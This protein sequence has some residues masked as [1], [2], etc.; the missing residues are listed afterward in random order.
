[1]ATTSTTTSTT[2]SPQQAALAALQAALASTA[3]AAPQGSAVLAS[4]QA[5][6]P[7]TL[8]QVAQACGFK[9]R[10]R[11]NGKLVWAPL[12]GT[13]RKLAS[14]GQVVSVTTGGYVGNNGTTVGGTAYYML[15]SA[16]K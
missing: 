9:P 16:G 11:S 6:K 14:A 1:M 4:L 10:K 7:Y 5:G 8:R 2:T 3:Q 13:L 15:V 12:R